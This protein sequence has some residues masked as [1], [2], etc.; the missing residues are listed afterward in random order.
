[1][2]VK[3]PILKFQLDRDVNALD[4]KLRSGKVSR[5]IELTES[6]YVDMDAEDVP[7]GIE[8][9]DAD[10]FVPYLRAHVDAA[11]LPPQVREL[12]RVTAV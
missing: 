12:F 11:G 6:V 1:V 9:L 3:G 8:F 7:L 2:E 4:I 10:E 5:T